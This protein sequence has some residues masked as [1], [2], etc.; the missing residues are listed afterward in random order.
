MITHALGVMLQVR[1][2]TCCDRLRF[3]LSP[4]LVFGQIN[5]SGGCVRHAWGLVTLLWNLQCFGGALYVMVLGGYR[6]VLGSGTEATAR[7]TQHLCLVQEGL[8]SLCGLLRA[9]VILKWFRI[10]IFSDTYRVV[11]S[12]D[13]LL[14]LLYN[15][16]TV[17]L[18]AQWPAKVRA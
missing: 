15:F 1:V 8:V 12:L 17:R 2:R 13:G 9:R 14:F 4:L 16:V 18:D 3:A 5:F 6:R 11:V 7:Q 10:N